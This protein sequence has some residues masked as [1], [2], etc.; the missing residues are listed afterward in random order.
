MSGSSPPSPWSAPPRCHWGCRWASA[1]AAGGTGCGGLQRSQA[2]S[3]PAGGPSAGGP[4]RAAGVRRPSC[5]GSRAAGTDRPLGCCRCWSA[6][7][8]AG[9]TART[10]TARFRSRSRDPG[11]VWSRREP[12]GKALRKNHRVRVEPP[13]PPHIHEAGGRANLCGGGGPGG[14]NSSSASLNRTN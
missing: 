6:A 10:A 11:G 12:H 4:G 2:V 13:S 7:G 5:S 1:G 14:V 3:D 9:P 8:P